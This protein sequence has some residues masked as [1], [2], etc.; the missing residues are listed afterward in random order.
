MCDDNK[1][2]KGCVMRNGNAKSNQYITLQ[3]SGLQE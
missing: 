3:L 1:I 2:G